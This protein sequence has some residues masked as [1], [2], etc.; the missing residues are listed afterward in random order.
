[1]AIQAIFH[2][3]NV[4]RIFTGCSHTI[5][6]TGATADNVVMIHA[7]HRCKVK[8]VV[9]VFAEIGRQD[10]G[11]VL[12]DGDDAIVAADTVVT[13]V[14][15]VVNGAR[16]GEGSMAVVADIAA[17]D[18]PRIFTGRSHPVVTALAGADDG[19]VIDPGDG[20]PGVRLMAIVT[21]ARYSNMLV[22]GGA[23][24]DQPRIGMALVTPAGGTGKYCLYVAIL[25]AHRVVFE[26]QWEAGF[27]VVEFGAEIERQAIARGYQAE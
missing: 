18:V 10:V 22:G 5:V 17:D 12:A 23:G 21:V 16:P 26:I 25:A 6:A 11:W 24:P 3:I 15:M 1:M 4:A 19:K 9:A 27:I 8:R 20:E 2:G 14:G 7:Y 13:D